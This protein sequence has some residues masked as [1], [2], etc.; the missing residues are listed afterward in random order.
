MCLA[1]RLALG[2]G[3]LRSGVALISLLRMQ[4]K[5]TIHKPKGWPKRSG[6]ESLG[7]TDA[8]NDQDGFCHHTGPNATKR[9]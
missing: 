7:R 6:V 8:E 9:D 2:G 3:D 1:S 4:F 5:P